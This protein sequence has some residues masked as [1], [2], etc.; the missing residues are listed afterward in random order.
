LASRH[1]FTSP[2][3]A[4]NS[5]SSSNQLLTAQSNSANIFLRPLP[6]F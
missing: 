4:A 3:Q 1:F 6:C 5:K 2:N